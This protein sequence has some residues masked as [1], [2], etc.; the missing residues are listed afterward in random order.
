MTEL[1]LV[2]ASVQI[3]IAV[4]ETPM[5]FFPRYGTWVL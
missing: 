5:T 4:V 2:G 1:W 3:V